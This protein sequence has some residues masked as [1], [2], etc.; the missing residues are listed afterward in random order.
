MSTRILYLAECTCHTEDFHRIFREDV[1][2]NH[3]LKSDE[4]SF[5]MT[6]AEFRTS[7]PRKREL[8]ETRKHSGLKNE[9]DSKQI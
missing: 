9:S 7:Q 3:K 5:G 1:D 2:N 4:I 8:K 6:N